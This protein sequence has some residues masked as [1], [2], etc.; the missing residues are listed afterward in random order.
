MKPPKENGPEET[1]PSFAV[2]PTKAILILVLVLLGVLL[3]SW[4]VMKVEK[5]GQ[6]QRAVPTPYWDTNSTTK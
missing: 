5:P 2:S 6:S 1:T 3:G 4:V